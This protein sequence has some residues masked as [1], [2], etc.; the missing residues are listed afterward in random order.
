MKVAELREALGAYDAATLR[1]L[2]VELYKAVPAAKKTEELDGLLRAFSKGARLAAPKT[3]PVDFGALEYEV[4][5]F[6]AYADEGLFFQPN[7]LV[8]KARRS[9]WRFEV[10][11]FI[12]QLVAARGEDTEDAA[13][14]LLTVYNM[15]SCACAVYLFP[16]EDPFAAVGHGQSDLL[17]L[18][19]GKLLALGAT[20][21][22]IALAVYTTLDS[23]PSRETWHLALL[24]TLCGCL[25]TNPAR[26][27]AR[28]VAKSFPNT[29]DGYLASKKVFRRSKPSSYERTAKENEAVE[30]YLMLSFALHEQ[31]EGIAY[32]KRRYKDR[33]PEVK[34]Y[35]LLTYF[36][37]D[38]DYADLWL[39]EYESAVAKGVSPRPRLVEEYARRTAKVEVPGFDHESDQ[40]AT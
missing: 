38:D 28:D 37:D 35:I 39:R 5:T 9:K 2:A 1:E 19:L 8:P 33:N 10:R 27:S 22:S 18:A 17:E 20:E 15:L 13:R 40:T 11:R 16:S 14:L 34:L 7:R 30:L 21:E 3:V 26:E 29:Y 25:K 6:V 4:A 24:G 32:F 23:A 31:E 36:L 12:K